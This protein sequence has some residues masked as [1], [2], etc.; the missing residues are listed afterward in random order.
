[1]KGLGSCLISVLFLG[2]ESVTQQQLG[3]EPFCDNASRVV[4]GITLSTIND[5]EVTAHVLL[6]SI[7][8]EQNRS[9]DM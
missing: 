1:M 3:E 5:C 8:V 4:L 9:M 2:H 6:L 7:L